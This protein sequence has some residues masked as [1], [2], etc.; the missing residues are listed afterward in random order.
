M[1]GVC[2]RAGQLSGGLSGW[3]GPVVPAVSSV[4]P[5]PHVEKV[6]LLEW[7]NLGWQWSPMSPSRGRGAL[8]A[9][10]PFPTVSLSA[11]VT[12]LR[13]GARMS[14]FV[15]EVRQISI[16]EVC[17]TPNVMRGLQRANL[18]PAA[19]PTQ[20]PRRCRRSSDLAR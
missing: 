5:T 9:E 10:R 16:V 7:K 14:A 8:S 11:H 1:P 13:H 15:G 17:I 6:D 12:F 18:Q 19:H 20:R 2:Q 3:L 4:M